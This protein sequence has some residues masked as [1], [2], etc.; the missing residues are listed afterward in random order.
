MI[1]KKNLLMFMIFLGGCA[2]H[3]TMMVNPKN[4]DV[5]DCHASGAG[6]ILAMMAQSEHDSCVEDL[7]QLG[8]EPLKHDQESPEEPQESSKI[9]VPN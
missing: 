7:R 2:T 4:G 9:R 8:F 6:L 3:S 5:Y 1:N